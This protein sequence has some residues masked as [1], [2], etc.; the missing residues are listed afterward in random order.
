MNENMTTTATYAEMLTR[1]QAID[2]RA[3][4]S[5]DQGEWVI[6][7]RTGI[8][9]TYGLPAEFDGTPAAEAFASWD[10]GEP[11][12]E[13]WARKNGH[14]WQPL[15]VVAEYFNIGQ[16]RH[17]LHTDWLERELA[18]RGLRTRQ[19][20]LDGQEATAAEKELLHE[21]YSSPSPAAAYADEK[22]RPRLDALHAAGC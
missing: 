8:D 20:I 9:E 17:A 1:A 15:H 18:A 5:L 12:L 7:I 13:R 3:T 14:G 6:T 22:L 19:Q 4:V 2:G 21:F 10:S 11:V 16:E